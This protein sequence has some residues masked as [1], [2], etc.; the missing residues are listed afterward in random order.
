MYFY[1]FQS[2]QTLG[3]RRSMTFSY[4]IFSDLNNKKN[5]CTSSWNCAGVLNIGTDKV[6]YCLL[7]VEV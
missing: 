4:S 2:Q 3:L 1:K 5:P 6:N 7:A